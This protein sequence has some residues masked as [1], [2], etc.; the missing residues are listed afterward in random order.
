MDML[1]RT[2]LDFQVYVDQVNSDVVSV[3]RHC[4]ES[5]E[6]MIIVAHTAFHEPAKHHLPTVQDSHKYSADVPPMIIPGMQ[7]DL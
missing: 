7:L 1:Y 6:S 3:T 5:H 4:P 2:L